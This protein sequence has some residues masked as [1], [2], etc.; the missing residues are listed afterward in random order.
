MHLNK[1]LQPGLHI[2]FGL[3]E[4]FV[5]QKCRGKTSKSMFIF[6]KNPFMKMLIHAVS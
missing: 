4:L 1:A 5:C 2:P 3:R 6:N